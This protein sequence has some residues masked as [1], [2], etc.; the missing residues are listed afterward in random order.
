MAWIWMVRRAFLPLMRALTA[1]LLPQVLFGAQKLDM[2]NLEGCVVGANCVA[3]SRAESISEPPAPSGPLTVA[4]ADSL[5]GDRAMIEAMLA[6]NP[7]VRVSPKKDDA[8]YLVARYPDFPDILILMPIHRMA[9]SSQYQRQLFDSSDEGIAKLYE[10]Y[11]TAS[12][13]GGYRLPL[14]VGSISDASLPD[15]LNL[16]LGQIL[17]AR[18]LLFWRGKSQTDVGYETVY[19]DCQGV[20]LSEAC[21]P[22]QTLMIH[23]KSS[24][25]QNVALG[26]IDPHNM[27]FY[28]S[29][30]LPKQFSLNPGESRSF[31]YVEDD[32][33]TV[34]IS[35][36]EPIDLNIVA[37]SKQTPPELPRAWNISVIIPPKRTAT[38]GGGGGVVIS[39]FTAP[40]QAQLYS[41]D[42]GTPASLRANA[43]LGKV[44]WAQYEKA[45]RCGGSVIGLDE[46]K[47]YIV[48][49]AAHCV[50]GEPFAGPVLRQNAL[51][52]RRVRLG[53]LDLT[54]GGTTYAIDSI[55]VHKGYVAGQQ[56]NDIAL[57]RI[58]PD[59]STLSQNAK[60]VRPITLATSQPIATTGVKWYGWGFMEATEGR[61]TRMTSNNVVQRNPSQLHEG[62]MQLIDQKTCSKRG[63]YG[64]VTDFMLC[65]VTPLKSKV[66]VFT[67]QGDSGGPI[68]STQNGKVMQ[69]GIVSWAVGCGVK[70]KPSVSVNVARYRSWIKEAQTKFV[71]GKSVEYSK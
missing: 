62:R 20:E 3:Q 47:R 23:N 53:T 19:H 15:Q 37:I 57:L 42:S 31:P 4:I 16:E 9:D 64:K 44:A 49:T 38:V 17:L 6:I 54:K 60:S 69:V 30:N 68:T 29:K 56:Y 34:I 41:T 66:E 21:V 10:L 48:L 67:C 5:A 36:N 11:A 46:N 27:S 25:A 52:F 35:A 55:V 14:V 40:W 13:P 33:Y 18:R 39:L 43:T 50:A 65:A 1:M 45:H 70:G 2:E 8:D 32:Q 12:F 58:R 59:S 28:L 61:V 24:S 51:K 22:S 7:N 63:G 26:L 71:S